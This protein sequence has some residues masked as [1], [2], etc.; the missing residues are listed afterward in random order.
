MDLSISK[1]DYCTYL[2]CPKALWL[3]KYHPELFDSST[4]SESAIENGHVVGELATHLFSD[5]KTVTFDE[6]LSNMI[7]ETKRYIDE[8]AHNIAEASFS[9]N[10]LFCSVD[11]LSISNNIVKI[12]EVKSSTHV[13]ERYIDDVS[14][15][16]YVLSKLGY[17]VDS[18]YVVYINKGYVRKGDL[19]LTEYFAIYDAT[20]DAS[21]RYMYVEDNVENIHRY[22]PGAS[23][24]SFDICCCSSQKD[25]GYSS[26][27]WQ[28]LPHPNVFDISRLGKDRKLELYNEGI[29][30][31][32]D[33]YKSGCKLT[34]PQKM[35]VEYE[36]LDKEPHVD[37]EK[38]RKFL[39]TLTYPLYHLDFESYQPVVPMYDNYSSYSQIPFQYSLHIQLDENSLDHKE[40][41]GQ[42]GCD[43]RR[44]LA[45]QLVEDIPDNVCVLAYNMSFEKSIIRNLADLYPDLSDHLMK[46]H[47]NIKDLM[48]PF[49]SRYYYSKELQ[50]SYSIKY[51]LPALFPNDPTL[52]YHSLDNVHNGSEAM[53]AFATLHL[54]SK[55][56][57]EEI[58]H[59]LLEY[60]KLDTLAMVKIL[61]KLKELS[62]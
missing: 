13:T 25:C 45:C 40:F 10:G 35:Q 42:A 31:F 19:D 37:K 51:V 55:E 5:V 47:D 59:S 58:R 2:Q 24:D 62:L 26:H 28:H 50:G 60:C 8:G 6:N 21:D 54:K 1:S 44:D 57:Q 16:A 20:A 14:F 39:S 18:V 36:Y 17:I 29:V 27:C 46:I 33:V 41:L 61:E 48:V 11:I 43:P 9:Y 52:D 34:K 49:Q 7:E 12:Y 3:D 15:Q 56:E 32:E 53:D 22:I 38:I 4:V 30:T 23:E